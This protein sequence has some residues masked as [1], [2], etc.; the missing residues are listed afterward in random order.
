M[1][2]HQFFCILKMLFLLFMIMWN[3]NGGALATQGKHRNTHAR[4]FV[5]IGDN[6]KTSNHNDW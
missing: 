3:D 1:G 6:R 5:S 2:N 4:L